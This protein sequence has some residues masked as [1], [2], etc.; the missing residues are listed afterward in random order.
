VAI[1]P[2]SDLGNPLEREFI[3]VSLSFRNSPDTT[4]LSTN[5][6][7]GCIFAST[8]ELLIWQAELAAGSD[9]NAK[10]RTKRSSPLGSGKG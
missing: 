2:Q 10:L 7:S 8:L 3:C 5:K 6:L 4:T 1:V 9:C